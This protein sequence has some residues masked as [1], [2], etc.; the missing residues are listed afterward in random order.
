MLSDQDRQELVGLV[1]KECGTVLSP[2][3]PIFASVMMSERVLEHAARAV[4]TH[5]SRHLE[6]SFA[7]HEAKVVR[8][9]GDAVNAELH[10]LI[11]AGGNARTELRANGRRWTT[12][13]ALTAIL[14]LLSL[15]ALQW[16]AWP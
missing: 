7:A 16:G 10:R 9:V 13:L 6:T 4:A 5:L 15:S 14:G 1:A 3:D 11:V 12:A 2:D 8:K